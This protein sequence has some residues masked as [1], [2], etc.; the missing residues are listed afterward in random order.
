MLNWVVFSA[1]ILN[2]ILAIYPNKNLTAA[3]GWFCSALGWL[4]VATK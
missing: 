4:I 1:S 3:C 2:M